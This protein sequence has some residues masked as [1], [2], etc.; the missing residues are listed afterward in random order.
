[1][2]TIT[3]A[4]SFRG[5]MKIPGD[6]S[7]SHR[8]I[9]LGALADGDTDVTDFLESADC[10]STID[11]FSRLGVFVERDFSHPGHL[12]VHGCGME[13][14]HPSF[15]TVALYTGNSGTTTRILS[16]ILAPQRFVSLVSGDESV[17]K[18]PMNRV[19]TPLRQMGARIESMNDDGCA[20]L[21]ITGTSLHGISYVSPVASAQV[22]S[23]ILLA[24]LYA[25]GTTTVTEPSPSRDHTERMLRAFGA[26][27]DVGGNSGSVHHTEHLTPI[28]IQVPGDIS[29]AAYFIAAAAIVPGS[30]VLLRHVG[31]NPTR[32]GILRVA[33]A[34]G[35]DVTLLNETDDAEP[36]ADIL[37]RSS[38]LHGTK[39]GGDLIPTL[40]D[41]LPVVAVMAACAEGTTVIKDA[42]EL[43]VKESDRIRAMTEG[44]TAMGCD[45]TGTEDGMIIH[46]G[47]ALRGA[48]IHTYAD[49]RI[50][51]SFAV[52]GL[53]ADG[54]TVLDDESC[55]RISYPTFFQ[56]LKALEQ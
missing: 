4:N 26:D 50:A 48:Q 42:A 8:S 7:I 28:K 17:N 12:I 34:M 14:L 38:C 5:E 3:K 47:K 55:V 35:A 54:E 53:I 32:D 46:G 30:E 21:E 13:G 37:V 1:M 9:M 33:K 23:A 24:G 43:R 45:V 25:D 51:M 15:H 52:A 40:I 31:I 44:L 56:D 29:S 41:E 36:C 39:I 22:K 19:I 16:G 20:P 27:V 11:C 6:K 18:R 10:L 49:H 2:L